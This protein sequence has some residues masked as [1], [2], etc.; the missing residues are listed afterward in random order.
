MANLIPL[1]LC[2]G[3]GTRLW[4][5][6]RQEHPKQFADLGLPD[7][8]FKLTLSRAESVTSQ[9]AVIVC[10][11][12]HR[13]YV[14]AQSKGFDVQAVVVEPS[15]RNTAA[16]VIAACL[17]LPPEALVLMLPSDHYMP[18]VQLLSETAQQAAALAEAGYLVQ[19][20]IRAT[21]PATGYGYILPGAAIG[22]GFQIARMKEKPSASEAEQLVNEG[23][24]W[25]SG[26]L[27]FKVGTLLAEAERCCPEVLHQTVIAVRGEGVATSG[28]VRPTPAAYAAIPSI[29]LDY[30][31]LERTTRAAVIPYEG[32]WSDLGTWA[33]LHEHPVKDS[34]GNVIVGE[35]VVQDTENTLVLANSRLV[36]V[37]GVSDLVVVE[38]PD[39]ILVADKRKPESVKHVV[40][41]LAARGHAAASLPHRVNRPW[42]WYESLTRDDVQQS[43][44]LHVNQG[45]AISLQYHNRRAEHWVVIHG[46]ATVQLDEEVKVLNPGESVFIPTGAV[47][48]LSAPDGDVEL[49]EVQTGDYFGEDDIIRLS[50]NYERT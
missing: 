37:S 50:D 46:R 45:A 21:H 23:Y 2:G 12:S 44:R 40:A 35:A 33:S 38:T 24:L 26:M 31:V 3:S 11:E 20:G 32:T 49:I 17:G 22:A 41:E 9:P 13:F 15:A 25:N 1:I 47:H 42:G 10:G 6:S 28:V 18:D 27:V 29:S 7:T 8:L 19:L 30:A 14:Q 39:A 43:K 5:V 34:W 16:A 48:R 36:C 4:P